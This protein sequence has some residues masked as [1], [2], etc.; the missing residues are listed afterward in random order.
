MVQETK[1]LHTV[2]VDCSNKQLS[3]LPENLPENTVLLNV[4]NNNV[5]NCKCLKCKYYIFESYCFI[6]HQ[7][8]CIGNRSNLQNFE[9][10]LC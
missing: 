1:T 2:E 5:K 4:T 7:Y 3:S 6:D 8:R 10:F 9:I